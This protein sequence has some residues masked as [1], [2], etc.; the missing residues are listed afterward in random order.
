MPRG[1]FGPDH[2][3]RPREEIL[4]F[5]EIVRLVEILACLGVTKVRLTGGEPLLRGDLGSL[6]TLVSPLPARAGSSDA[7]RL[8]LSAP[9]RRPVSERRRR[10]RPIAGRD[11]G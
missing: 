4:S 2:A 1:V 5:E 7:W 10:V 3:F 6:I 11:E 9:T 8:L